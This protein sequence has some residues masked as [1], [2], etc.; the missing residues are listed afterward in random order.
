MCA[1]CGVTEV[2]QDWYRHPLEPVAKLCH[3]C[4]AYHYRTGR[5][6]PQELFERQRLLAQGQPRC[7]SVC[8]T[9]ETH[10]WYLF[11]AERKYMCQACWQYARRHSGAMRYMPAPPAS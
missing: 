1:N 8:S 7:C 5:M 10:H 11:G 9:E 2:K 6:R 3:T 4:W